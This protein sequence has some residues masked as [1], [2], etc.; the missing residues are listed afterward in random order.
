M[1]HIKK[2]TNPAFARLLG[3]YNI[4]AKTSSLFIIISIFDMVIGY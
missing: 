1:P 2:I 3:I 4:D